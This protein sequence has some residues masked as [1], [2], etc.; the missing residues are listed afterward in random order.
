YVLHVGNRHHRHGFKAFLAKVDCLVKGVKRHHEI[1]SEIQDIKTRVCE[2]RERS[3]PY[4]FNTFGGGAEDKTWYLGRESIHGESNRTAISVV[5]MGGVARTTLAKK[6]ADEQI[7]TGHFDCHACIT[8][9]KDPC[10][11]EVNAMDGEELIGKCRN[12]LQEKSILLCSMMYGKKTWGEVQYALFGNDKSSRIMVTTRNRNVAEFCKTSALV[13]LA[14]EL[15]CRTAFQFDQEKQHPLELKDLSFDIA[16]KFEGLPLASVAISGLLN[17]DLP[18]HLK[19]C[20]LFLGMFPV[21]YVVNCARFIRLWIAE[22]FVKQQ[23]QQHDATAE[24]VARQ[25]LTQLINK[26]LVHVEL[27]DF[28]GMVRECRVHGLMHELILSKSDELNFFFQTSPTQLTNLNQTARHISIQ[29]IGSNNLSSTIRSSKAHS[30]I[31][32]RYK[33]KSLSELHKLETLDLKRSRLHQLPFEINKLSNLKYFIAY[34]DTNFQ[35]RQGVKIHGNVQSLKSIEKLY[36]VDV[37]AGKSFDLVSELGKRWD[38]LCNAIEQMSLHQSLQIISAKEEEPLQ[39]QSMTSPLLLY[40]LRL[41]ARLEKLPHWISDLKCLIPLNILGELPKLLE[42]FL[43]KGC[44]GTQVHFE[45][46]YIPAL[47]ILILEKLD[48]LNRLAIDE[49]ALHLVEHLFIGSCQQLKMLPSDICHIKCLSVF[50]VSLMSKEF[51]RRMLPGVDEDH[52]KVQN[53]A[54]VHVYIINTE[55][56]YLAYKLGDSTL[57]DSLN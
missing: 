17:H 32:L 4:S 11:S 12:F 26:N 20:F 56:Q 21:D 9:R 31:F 39:L 3:K 10:P 33:P 5:G 53:I 22:G 38:A 37:D 45:S 2:I 25:S 46:G 15:L 51:V 24:D 40:C 28:N 50:E 30:I 7:A 55:Q 8:S 29:N 42:L 18:Y 52:W 43:Y 49:N 54:N 23:Q 1:A 6:V 16:K 47:K 34:S 36:L 13:H 27:I 48:R 44:N 14:Q 19:S 57:L 41:Q 35:I